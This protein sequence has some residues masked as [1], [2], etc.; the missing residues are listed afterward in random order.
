MPAHDLRLD[1]ADAGEVAELLEFL[2]DWLDGSDSTLL[3]ASLNRFVGTAGYDLDE[4]RTD[5]TRF[6]FLLGANDGTQL[7]DLGH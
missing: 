4:L 7:F 1:A 5:L 2:G 6:T 3:A